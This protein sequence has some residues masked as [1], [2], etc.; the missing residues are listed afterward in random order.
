MFGSIFKIKM[1]PAAEKNSK[2]VAFTY[3]MLIVQPGCVIYIHRIQ[4]RA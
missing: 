1:L 3:V 4:I 2:P